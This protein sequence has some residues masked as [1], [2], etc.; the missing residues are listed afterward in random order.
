MSDVVLTEVSD[1]VA[2]VTLNRP[3]ARNALD[4]ALT[5]ALPEAIATCDARDDVDAIVLTGAE[6]AFCAGVDLKSLGSDREVCATSWPAT[7]TS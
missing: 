3:E 1:R 6:P 4:P 5:A 2:V 7:P